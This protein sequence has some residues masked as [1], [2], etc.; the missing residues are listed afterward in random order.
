MAE[1]HLHHLY[2]VFDWFREHNLKLKLS[3]CDFFGNE[4]TY[5][6]HRVLKDSTCPSNLNLEATAECTPPQTYMEVHTF[7]SLAGHY[8]RFIKRFVHIAQPLSEYLMREGAS[9]KFREGVTHQGCHGSFLSIET[10]VH[11]SCH[12][13][14]C[15]LHQTIPVGDQCVQRWIG[16]WCCHRSRQMGS[17]TP[18]PYGSRVLTPHKENYHSSKLK[19]LA[20]KWEVTEHFKE[21]LPYQSFVVWMDNNPLMYIMSTPNL[22]AMGHLWVGA[23]AQFDFELEYQKGHDNT[24]TDVLSWVTTQLNPETA[25]SMLNGVTLG[26]AHHAKLHNPA[27]MEGDQCLEQEVHVTAGYPLVEIHVTDWAK[28][29][30]EDSMLTA[31]LDWLKAQKQ[32]DLKMLLAEQTSSEKGKLILWEPTEDLLLFVVPKAHHVAA[33]NGYHWDTGY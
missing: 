17:T 29:Q 11:D 21:Y 2:I 7:L 5:L 4:I 20:W 1:K 9:R 28:A 23:L 3:K 33:L 12:I 10:G 25:K 19:F 13:G 30:R 18:L 6:V 27:M 22:D 26:M 15:W 14:V 32:T 31:V 16:G 8:R 24:V